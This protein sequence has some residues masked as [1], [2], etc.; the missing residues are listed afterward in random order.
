MILIHFSLV[1]FFNTCNTSLI[2]SG[3]CCLFVFSIVC[4]AMLIV[5]FIHGSSFRKSFLIRFIICLIFKLL[6]IIKVEFLFINNKWFYQGVPTHRTC[7]VPLHCLGHTREVE[8]VPTRRCG[9]IPITYSLIAYGTLQDII[10]RHL[11]SRLNLTPPP[12]NL[13]RT[14]HLIKG[15]HHWISNSSRRHISDRRCSL[16]FSV[17]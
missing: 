12:L 13:D 10:A 9:T 6:V 16:V 8:L 2:T 1:A 5:F 7:R 14:R 11:S 3:F 4:L 15:T 17:A